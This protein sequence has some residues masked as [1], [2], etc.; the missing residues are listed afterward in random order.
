M[1]SYAYLAVT[2]AE[3]E[4]QLN[5][6]LEFS[7]DKIREDTKKFFFPKTYGTCIC[8]VQEACED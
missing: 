8:Y 5:V 4:K 2:R 6:K 1:P 7:N 3:N